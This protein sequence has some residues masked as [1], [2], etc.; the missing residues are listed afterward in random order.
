MGDAD[1]VSADLRATKR[2]GKKGS[3]L[4]FEMGGELKNS[5]SDKY[6]ISETNYYGIEPSDDIRNQYEDGDLS[7]TQTNS[8]VRF[9]MPL[10]EDKMSLD[11]EYNYEGTLTESK[12]ATYD[13][14]DSEQDYSD[15]NFDQSTDFTNENI[16]STPEVGLRYSSDRWSFRAELGYDFIN[17]SS[18]DAL[19]PWLNFDQDFAQ[20]RI[21]SRLGY[22][23]KSKMS[24][25]LDYRLRNEA[26][27]I[28]ELQP[29]V[30][31][32]NPLHIIKGNPA[33]EVTE[34][35]RLNARFNTNNFNKRFSFF[36]YVNLSVLD[37]NVVAKSIIDEN[38]VKTTTYANVDGS[39]SLNMMLNV[40]Q[41]I[42][43]DSISNLKI[44][45]GMRPNLQR[46]VNFNNEVE[47]TSTVR[48]LAPTVGLVYDVTDI[49]EIESFYS[50]QFSKGTY[51][52]DS[53]DDTAFTI[54]NIRLNTALYL[55]KDFE[56][57]N[58]INF[59]Y[60]SNISD[61][62]QKSSWLWNSTLSYSVLKDTGYI[63]LKAYDILN[64]NTNARRIVNEDY[65]QDSESNVLQQYFLIGFSWKF[66]SLGTK[67]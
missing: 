60:N 36:G 61:G 27:S 15:F 44:V 28:A 34:N 19:R 23:I 13:Y 30:D 9:R 35:H 38:L 54:H 50:A 6:L 67:S 2:I 55:P 59:N 21:G 39:Y 11:V 29:Y 58:N 18:K 12:L 52:I 57:R 31:I 24:F 8:S 41:K 42:R 14:N 5:D 64:Q 4:R 26:P 16:T 17:L 49:F 3:F 65:I 56:W 63:T 33:L 1:E 10:I 22:N 20:V 47:Y 48:A 37:N 45:A 46:S 62:F 32:S 66:N 40:S 51:S 53:F 25:R 43:L 7:E